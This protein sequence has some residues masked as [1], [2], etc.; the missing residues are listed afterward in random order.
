MYQWFQSNLLNYNN[1]YIYCALAHIIPQRGIIIYCRRRRPLFSGPRYPLRRHSHTAFLPTPGL[2]HTQYPP[3][4]PPVCKRSENRESHFRASKRRRHQRSIRS[5][6][7][8]SFQKGTRR[9]RLGGGGGGVVT[10]AR[11]GVDGDMRNAGAAATDTTRRKGS[12]A[13]AAARLS[14]KHRVVFS[15]RYL[16]RVFVYRFSRLCVYSRTHAHASHARRGA[17]FFSPSPAAPPNSPPACV[18]ACTR[19]TPT[20]V[21]SYSKK[22]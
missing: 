5:F 18:R 1:T 12:A 17:F 13:A 3:P 10:A 8:G 11:T 19:T 4:P 21:C 20:H 6:F 9:R 16:P 7:T 22:G 14:T 2:P 15:N